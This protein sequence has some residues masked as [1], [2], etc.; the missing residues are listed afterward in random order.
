[1]HDLIGVL[2]LALG[3]VLATIRPLNLGA[4]LFAGAFLFGTFVAG[5]DTSKILAEFPVGIFLL[6]VGVTYL[7]NVARHNG[8]I[9]WF[10]EGAV[11]LARGRVALIPW[12]MFSTAALLAAVGVP[13]A[14]AIISPVAMGLATNRG[15]SQTFMAIMVVHGAGA[16]A[17]SPLGIFGIVVSGMMRQYAM[18]FDPIGIFV[19]AF[20]VNFVAAAIVAAFFAFTK[21]RASA[22]AT[23]RVQSHETEVSRFGGNAATRRAIAPERQFG[24]DGDAPPSNQ[25]TEKI[26]LDIILTM[27]AFSLLVA[28]AIGGL[29]IGLMAITCAI[30]L[31]IFKSKY[32]TVALIDVP[33][34]LIFLVVGTITYVGVIEK[35][36]TMDR[37]GSFLAGAVAPT[38]AAL[39]LAY[40]AGLVSAFA[41]STGV[42]TALIPPAIPL[43]EQSDLSVL[44]VIGLIVVASTIVDVSPFSGQGASAIANATPDA[45]QSVFR[46]MLIYGA[47]ITAVGPGLV[48][49]VLVLPGVA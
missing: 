3:F 47:V 31:A 45:R 46:S 49:L 29:D 27:V 8:T 24:A 13:A 25:E 33:W 17:L 4:L 6:L 10:V 34:P 39:L 19:T 36:G 7:A 44:A 37:L 16:G 15:I 21:E 43:L 30:A 9:D 1:M 14:P 42:M 2:V 41:S 35:I 12:M 40:A 23:A 28:G 11:N 18:P 48:W 32:D 38:I 20:L 26:S 22:A 5:L